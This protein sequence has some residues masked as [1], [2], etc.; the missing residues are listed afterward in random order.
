MR[1]RG[2]SR[3]ALAPPPQIAS[4]FLRLSSQRRGG[5]P[6]VLL[7]R[8]ARGRCAARTGVVAR[9]RGA[10]VAIWGGVGDSA[11]CD[12]RRGTGPPLPRIA[13]AF[14]RL[15]SQRWRGAWCGMTHGQPH[16][17]RLLRRSAELLAK[18]GRGRCAARA[19]VVARRRAADVAIWGG[20]GDGAPSADAWGGAP[21]CSAGPAAPGCFGAL[22]SFS[23]RR[24]VVGARTLAPPHPRLLRRS[25][26]LLAKTRGRSCGAARKDGAWSVRG[27]DGCRCEEAGCRRGNLGWGG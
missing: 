21:R 11:P 20:V 12:T 13:S 22:R 24:R 9:R 27:A 1:G 18:T 7:A 15:S 26:E 2:T 5:V 6:A 3:R 14:L 23:Q 4:S 16:R 10:D 8:T 19:G 25:E 17:T